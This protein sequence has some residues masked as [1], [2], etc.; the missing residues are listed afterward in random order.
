MSPLKVKMAGRFLNR[1]AGRVGKSIYKS[2][3]ELI[4][5]S[6]DSYSRLV[7]AGKMDPNATREILIVWDKP[8]SEF[9]VVDHA[10]GM[11]DQDMIEKFSEY[12]KDTSGS[13]QGAPVRGLFG[14][15]ISDVLFFHK[16]GR[17]ESI[18]DR[19]LYRCPFINDGGEW[20]VDPKR[21]R[22]KVD[23]KLRQSLRIPKA[24]GTAVSFSPSARKPVRRFA[25]TLER[26]PT[27]RLINSQANKVVRYIE[28]DGTG[29]QMFQDLRYEFPEGE[30]LT[31]EDVSF[32]YENKGVVTAR[33][34]L[35]RAPKPL[36]E[37]EAGLLVYDDKEAVYDLTLFGATDPSQTIFGTLR[38]TGAREIIIGA[39]NQ[40]EPEEIVS[41]DR[42]GFVV[43]HPFYRALQGAVQPV[44]EPHISK[45]SPQPTK[46]KLSDKQRENQRKALDIFNN[47][48]KDMIEEITP[49][50][51]P[52]ADPTPPQS[53]IEFD[54]RNITAT[55]GKTYRLGVNLNVSMIP[56]GSV[57]SLE[58]D[59]DTIVVKPE[60]F[61]V[62]DDMVTDGLARR[63]VTI[64]GATAGESGLV[65]ATSGEYVAT[66]VATITNEV[67]IYPDTLSFAPAAT[68]VQP[69]GVGRG[70]LFVNTS[71]IP[72][73]TS[74]R[75][76][77]VTST[78]EVALEDDDHVL[79][80]EDV[81][82]DDVV[83]LRLNF[84]AGENGRAEICATDGMYTTTLA[85]HVV[86]RKPNEPEEPQGKFADWQFGDIGRFQC[87]YDSDKMSRTYGLLV[88][89]RS[90]ALNI[91][92]F[93]A[94]PTKESVGKSMTA[95]AYLADLLLDAALDFMLSEKWR[96]ET[97]SGGSITAARDPHLYIQRYLA[98]EKARI[99][100]E[101]HKLFI[102]EDLMQKHQKEVNERSAVG[103]E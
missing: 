21:T 50:T 2:L 92:Y 27:L 3:G 40:E 61:E 1:Q 84:I 35:R 68:T 44:I 96:Q 82:Y 78:T 8:K 73:G 64:C 100:P 24:N 54:R 91:L 77:V 59:N 86:T 17:V 75:F 37:D 28:V 102:D 42:S 67:A 12:G 19:D 38:L 87:Y 46:D 85:V 90:H 34:E 93:G 39:M 81:A 55:E 88:V 18:V 58:C 23:E 43:H 51:K 45:I 63:L 95:S 11:T 31:S 5:N 10:E 16:R 26:L 9:H 32:S 89:N 83:R 7:A 101:F 79:V 48:Y 15:G 47:L 25:A 4:T 103:A 36:D 20:E 30:L 99:G 69:G 72:L 94:K 97:T 6:D 41:D 53:G 29:V 13:S 98:A 66:A 60:S 74:L 65:Q 57:V 33:I 80:E 22:A 56:V 76:E 52:G 14:Q 62:V 49:V 70:F 71:V